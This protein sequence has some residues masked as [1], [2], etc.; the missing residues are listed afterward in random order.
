MSKKKKN[1][2][3][4]DKLVKS[5]NKNIVI[6]QWFEDHLANTGPDFLSNREKLFKYENFIKC[7]F[8]LKKGQ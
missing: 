3:N 7:N 5:I 4:K 6:S 8:Q 1:N 2:E